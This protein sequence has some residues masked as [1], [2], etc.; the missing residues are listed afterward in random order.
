MVQGRVVFGSLVISMGTVILGIILGLR[1][2]AGTLGGPDESNTVLL[3]VV[4]VA[5]VAGACVLSF[6]NLLERL[7]PETPPGGPQD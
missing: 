3:V 7:E 5:L 1:Y 2:L 4:Y 6:T